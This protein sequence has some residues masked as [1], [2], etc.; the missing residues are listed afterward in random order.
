MSVSVVETISTHTLTWSVT[1]TADEHAD[2]EKISTH[3]LTWSV[4]EWF[5]GILD[6]SK[7]F[8]SHAHVERDF[9]HKSCPLRKLLIS[10]H[11][12][13]WSVT[14]CITFKISAQAISTH[15]LTWSVTV[16]SSQVL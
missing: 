8:N 11:T 2:R 1:S 14:I 9:H 15:T 7:D 3:T 4:T 13:T 5:I 12:L 6:K 16:S 10:T